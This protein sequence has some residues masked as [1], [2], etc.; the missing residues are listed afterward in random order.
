MIYDSNYYERLRLRNGEE[1]DLR[2]VRATDK[3]AF[4]RG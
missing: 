1:V 4:R 2:L 3:E